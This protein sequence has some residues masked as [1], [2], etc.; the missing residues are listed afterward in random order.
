[1]E[2]GKYFKP[3]SFSR[4]VYRKHF[5]THIDYLFINFINQDYYKIKFLKKIYQYVFLH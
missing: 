1:M 3:I 4:I 2:N 5:L